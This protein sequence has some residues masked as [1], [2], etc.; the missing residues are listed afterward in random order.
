M[1]KIYDPGNQALPPSLYDIKELPTVL[2]SNRASYRITGSYIYQ[3]AEYQRFF[4]KD[5]LTAQV[6]EEQ[7]DRASYSVMPFTVLGAEEDETTIYLKS[8]PFPAQLKLYALAGDG[9]LVW[10]DYS[11]TKTKIDEYDGEYYH[12]PGA[13]NSGLWRIID[14]EVDPW[15]DEIF[16]TGNPLVP[17]TDIYL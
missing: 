15:M 16:T 2:T 9:Y 3:K 4:G 13:P 5:Y 10:A 17:A 12:K 8:L 6:V 11:F 7:V 14:T 1:I